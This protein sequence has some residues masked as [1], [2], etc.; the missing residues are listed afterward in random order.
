MDE[1]ESV[2]GCLITFDDLTLVEHMNEQL[3]DRVAQLE[4]AKH[5]IERRTRSSNTWPITISSPAR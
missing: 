3:L 1:R 4:V 2:R 5:K